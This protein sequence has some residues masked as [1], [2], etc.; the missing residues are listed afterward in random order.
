MTKPKGL[1]CEATW[2]LSGTVP[3]PAHECYDERLSRGC[4]SAGGRNW[5]W[6]F[7]NPGFAK[8]KERWGPELEL[9]ISESWV[10]ATYAGGRNW[11]WEFRNPGFLQPTLGAGI[12]IGNFGILGFCNL[13]WGPELE[14]GISE[15]WVCKE[16]WGPEN[17]NW[18]FRN[19]E[20]GRTKRLG[21]QFPVSEFEPQITDSTTYL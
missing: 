6:E 3:V 18:E 7:R 4:T 11:N 12:G 19:P 13:R 2:F 1:P 9:G 5:N 8:S 20:E 10:F 15:S 14:S 17:W 21:L 16:R